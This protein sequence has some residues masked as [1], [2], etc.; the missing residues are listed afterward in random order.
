MTETPDPNAFPP[1]GG[2]PPPGTPPSGDPYS[3]SPGGQYGGTPPPGPPPGAP[4]GTPPGGYPP[5]PG[6]GGGDDKTW[7]LVTHFAGGGA[8][9][10]SGA[11]FGWVPPLIAFLAR[12]NQSPVVRAHAVDALN[13]QLTMTIAA[14]IGWILGAC[15]SIIIIGAIFFLVPLAASIVALIF[16]ILAGVKANNGEPFKYPMSIKM[17]K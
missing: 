17:I 15:G 6:T 10:I 13:F 2:Q 4:Y 11:I 5:G 8:A 14:V 16:G 1:P 12:G 9:F 7:I 3:K